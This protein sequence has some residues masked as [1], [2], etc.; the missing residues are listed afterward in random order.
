MDAQETIEKFTEFFEDNKKEVYKAIHKGEKALVI[1]FLK[2]ASFDHEIANSLLEEPEEVIKAAEIAL[3]NLN[4]ERELK[5]R[6][7]NLVRK[8]SRKSSDT[9]LKIKSIRKEHLD[10]FF[11]TEGIIRRASNIRPKTVSIKYECPSCATTITVLQQGPHVKQPSRC[12]CGRKGYFK[13]LSEETVDVQQLLIEEASDDLGEGLQPKQIKVLL[14]EDL[15]SERFEKK[16]SPGSRILVNGILRKLPIFKNREKSTVSDL[17]IEANF[18]EVEEEEYSESISREDEKKFLKFSKSKDVVK[19]ISQSIEPSIFGHEEIKEALTLQ[20]FGGVRKVKKNGRQVRGDTHIFLIGDPSSGKSI[21]GKALCNLVPRARFVSGRGSSGVGLC[22]SVVRD[23]FT[24]TYALEAGAIVLA[25]K[26]IL[27][28]DEIEKMDPNDITNMH[29]ALS[30]GTVSISKAGIQATLHAKTSVLGIANPKLGRFNIYEPLSEQ[31]TLSPTLLSRFDLIF[32]VL[33]VVD[34]KKDDAIIDSIMNTHKETEEKEMLSANFLRKYITY[35]KRINPK[36]TDK[37]DQTIRKFFK[38]LR[39]MGAQHENKTVAISYR[40]LEGMIRLSEASAKARLS[41]KV[42]KEDAERAVNLMTFCLSKIGM[43]PS[44]GVYDIDMVAGIP[45]S[46]KNKLETVLKLIEN[47]EKEN[48][49]SVKV[50]ELVEKLEGK[51]T[52]SEVDEAVEKL[53]REGE[54]MEPKQ[55]FVKTL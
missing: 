43:D 17:I 21:L 9:F 4:L 36:I 25:N 53:R 23:P 18:L 10:K 35:A 19:K 7:K 51:M 8:R 40:Q 45:A 3:E 55:G 38:K 11:Q 22:A 28:I 54:L 12:S 48:G 16:V 14:K 32:P 49:T 44:T 34:E 46:K 52:E 37:A 15:T 41:E 42:S 13:E 20:M 27:V 6:F 24:N 47:I 30:M 1:N 50:Q 39:K 26:S 33:D 29:E 5:V 2:L 31:I